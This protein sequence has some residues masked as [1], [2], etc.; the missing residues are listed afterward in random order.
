MRKSAKAAI[1]SA[2]I[3]LLSQ[4]AMAEVITGEITDWLHSDVYQVIGDDT[5]HV[6][7]WWSIN[8]YNRGWFYGRDWTG[9]SDVAYATDIVSIGQISD[10]SQYDFDS[11]S[12]GPFCDAECDPD[13]VGDF[14]IWRNVDTGYYGVLR[15]DDIIDGNNW[16]AAS[17][18]GTWWFQTDGTGNFSEAVATVDLTW[19]HVRALY[20]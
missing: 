16:D 1:V 4:G 5:N 19:G 20:R 2:T 11:H 12:I 10:A 3:L 15:I 6:T 9:D 13:G 17:L 8:T 18:N 7:M 14:I